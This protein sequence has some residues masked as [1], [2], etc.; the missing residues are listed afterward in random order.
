MAAKILTNVISGA[1][2]LAALKVAIDTWL[3]AGYVVTEVAVKDDGTQC[4]I[5]YYA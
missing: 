1:A 5:F 4:I 2:N 3:A